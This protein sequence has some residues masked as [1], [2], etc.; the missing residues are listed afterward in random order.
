VVGETYTCKL[1]YQDSS[2]QN[3]YDIIITINE[4]A[5][6]GPIV[7]LDKNNSFKQMIVPNIQSVGKVYSDNYPLGGGKVI[8]D[9][10]FTMISPWSIQGFFVN[11]LN[12]IPLQ[13]NIK[14][15]DPDKILIW[16][17]DPTHIMFS[18]INSKGEC[19]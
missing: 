1:S 18:E 4:D 13:I 9:A 16:I 6:I 12:F 17:Q 19:N 7:L 14:Q 5:N 11:M 8:A 10:Y 3:S 2:D 15:L